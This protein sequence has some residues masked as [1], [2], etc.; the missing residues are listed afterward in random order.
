MSKFYTFATAAV[1]SMA[2]LSVSAQEATLTISPAEGEYETLPTEGWALTIDGPESIKKMITAGNFMTFITPEGTRIAGASIT[3]TGNVVTFKPQATVPL[4][5]EGEYTVE[6]KA[7]ALQYTWADGTTSKNEL[8][9]FVYKIGKNDPYAANVTLD[10]AP[11]N[12][13]TLPTEFVFNIAGPEKIAKNIVGGGN[14]MAVIQP[15]GTTTQVTGTI[16]SAD[17]V[18]TV[19]CKIPASVPLDKNGDYT[20]RL[21]GNSLNYTW[22][23]GT[24]N[25][26]VDTDFTFHVEGQGEQPVEPNPVAYDITVKGYQPSLTPFDI[27]MKTLE[28]LQIVF[29]KGDLQLDPAANATVTISGPDYRQTA[30]LRNNMP[31]IGNFKA[32]FSSQPKYNGEYTL[33]IPQGVVGD[34]EWMENHEFGHANAAVNFTFTVIGGEE[35]GN[36]DVTETFNPVIDPGIGGKVPSLSRVSM[37]FDST[38]YFTA[39]TEVNVTYKADL[40]GA[41]TEFG[42]ATIEEGAENEVILVF[43][44]APKDKGQYLIN[45]PKG[46]L[47]D[48]EHNEDAEKGQI[49]AQMDLDWY[50]VPVVAEVNITGHTPATDAKIA[51][52]YVNEESIIINT[53]NNDAVAKMTV[54]VVRYLLDSDSGFSTTVLN[55][56]S[57]AKTANGDPC[58][59]NETGEDIKFSSSY[60]YEVTATLYDTDNNVVAD[61]IFEFYGADYVGVD[62]ITVDGA[63]EYFNLQGVRVANPGKGLYIRVQDGKAVKVVR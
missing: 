43:N 41:A 25:K 6:L 38:P 35:P 5:I 36:L 31:T 32:L 27:E 2:A 15:D 52:F 28:T 55:A 13:E 12:Y 47:W 17:G 46:I 45:F 14:P 50:L 8:T 7:N 63:A 53:D 56:T 49:N 4:D 9:N 10:P 16:V 20:I 61:T 23:D 18:N 58:W 19:T 24:K 39:G 1:M 40:Q 62:A 30:T 59:I 60:Y 48:A 44:P 26:S 11:G 42:T 3:L 57:T 33:T 37:T 54:K 34:A 51:G 22:A 21:R 29:S